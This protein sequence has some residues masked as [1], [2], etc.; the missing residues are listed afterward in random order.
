MAGIGIL[1][2][3][4][5]YGNLVVAAL[6]MYVL[7]SPV[8]LTIFVHSRHVIKLRRWWS[9]ILSEAYLNFAAALLTSRLCG[10]KV[11]LYS[12]TPDIRNDRGAL[13]LSNHRCRVDWM[14]SGFCYCS[15]IKSN[16][17]LR[18]IL[19]DSIRSVPFFG[20]IMS[21]M[22]Y[23]FLS[24]KDTKSDI[25]HMKQVIK[26]LLGSGVRPLTFIFPEGTDL[27][28]SSLA[29]SHK[30][31]KEH[32]LPQMDYVLC[33]KISGVE[34]VLNELRGS[35]AP[36]HDLTVAYRDH[37]VGGPRDTRPSETG[38]WTGKF[39]QEVHICVKRYKEVD[40]LPA[41]RSHLERWV[42]GSFHQKERLLKS[43]Y[44]NGS[45]V[46]KKTDVVAAVARL[47]NKTST[48]EEADKKLAGMEGW[49]AEIPMDIPIV[50]PMLIIAS[51]ILSISAMIYLFSW[52][53]WFLI[54]IVVFGTGAK[55]IGNGFDLIELYLHSS[56]INKQDADINSGD[57]KKDD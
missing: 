6:A 11:H 29:K 36:C 10:T 14:Y 42:I 49:P 57:S 13:V 24:R 2:G 34:V 28:P 33:P 55:A 31:C 56:I 5:L 1:R 37:H 39:P 32:Q 25:N 9:D 3:A 12:N 54:I 52:F 21:A 27:T 18:F 50:R 19:K 40:D 41:E 20:W 7:M 51:W 35:G 53:R 22:M 48:N 15:H 38:M 43:F 44:E 23:I 47:N 4:I 26:Y 30:Y 17:Q 16:G 45:V 46:P 8:Y